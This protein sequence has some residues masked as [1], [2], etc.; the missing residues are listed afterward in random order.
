MTS[1]NPY[2]PKVKISLKALKA[3]TVLIVAYGSLRLLDP[4]NLLVS[5]LILAVLAYQ[6]VH[7]WRSISDVAFNVFEEKFNDRLF[8]GLGIAVTAVVL[9]TFCLFYAS[10]IIVQRF[11]TVSPILWGLA[12][13]A[14]RNVEEVVKSRPL[15]PWWK[16]TKYGSFAAVINGVSYVLRGGLNEVFIAIDIDFLWILSCAILPISIRWCRDT[17]IV[18]G[19]V[20]RGAVYSKPKPS[21]QR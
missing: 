12:W 14:C 3:P 1:K 8:V 4:D 5:N 20:K 15:W 17:A 13:I 18:R 16:L 9:I 19:L 6:T 10:D 11:F 2:I 21:N 7:W